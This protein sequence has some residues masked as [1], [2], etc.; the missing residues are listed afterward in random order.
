MLFRTKNCAGYRRRIL[1]SMLLIVSFLFAFSMS[2]ALAG[3]DKRT[4]NVMTYNMD[5]GTDLGLVFFFASQGQLALGV[6]ATYGELL[7]SDISGRAALLADEIAAQQPYLISLQEVTLWRTGSSVSNANDV[8]FD[9][10]ELLTSALADRNQH[11]EVVAVQRLT[12]VA[13]PLDLSLIGMP[14]DP[15]KAALR[16]TDRDV[17]LA[18]TDLKQSELDLS[19]VQKHLFEHT[20]IVPLGQLSVTSLHGWISVDAKIR[21]KSVRFGCTH[22]ES[23]YPDT[24]FEVQAKGIQADQA[25]ELIE[26]MNADELPVILAGD[27][28]SDASGLDIGPDQTSTYVDILRAGYTD[29]WQLALLRGD[30]GLTWPL[31]LED[32]LASNPL[33]PI[34]RIDFIFA[35]D[36]TTLDVRR[37]GFQIP[38]ASDHAG[39]VAV[40]RIDK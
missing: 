28:N 39:V 1:V 3:S 24:P 29:A 10:L 5:A 7:Q 13:A 16:F 22:L 27:F 32:P 30:P 18:R 40:L 26:A 8:L 23:T 33:G 37:V 17:V 4:V 38:Y 31:F 36:M 14:A 6:S 11:Y 20:L 35:R 21:G 25:A 34:E 12:D 15:A 9:Q 19:N 2:P